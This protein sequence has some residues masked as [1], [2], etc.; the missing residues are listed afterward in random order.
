MCAF[1]G[2][3]EGAVGGIYQGGGSFCAGFVGAGVAIWV[4]EGLELQEFFAEGA[5]VDYEGAFGRGARGKSLGEEIVVYWGGGSLR[6][7]FGGVGI[8]GS[9]AT[10]EVAGMMEKVGAL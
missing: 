5:R 7:W 3:E 1:E 10:R 6:W 4:G 9:A 8:G 2:G